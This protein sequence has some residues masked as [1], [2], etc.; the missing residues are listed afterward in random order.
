MSQPLL[1]NAQ[2]RLGAFPVT[3]LPGVLELALHGGE[4]PLE[5]AL[6]D[7]VLRAGPHRFHGRVFPDRAGHEDER[8]VEPA[9]AHQR[10][11]GGA[12]EMGHAVIGEEDVPLLARQRRPQGVGGVDPLERGL[13]AAAPQLAHQQQGVVLGVLD[14][15]D[16][17][18]HSH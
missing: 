16:V 18:R 5:V 15:Q 14:D 4:Q 11:R 12:A 2:R 1:G 6:G 17:E 3:A 7:V 9:L 13:E 10:Q 8:Q